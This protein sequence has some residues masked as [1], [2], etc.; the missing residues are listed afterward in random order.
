MSRRPGPSAPYPFRRPQAAPVRTG[1]R[2]AV[3]ANLLAADAAAAQ[4]RHFITEQLTAWQLHGRLTDRVKLL[5]SELITNA[6]RHAPP[7]LRIHLAVD[8][9]RL[10]V[11][12]YDSSATPP[13]LTRPDFHHR[14][15]R[16]V[17]LVDAMSSRWGHHLHPPGKAVWFEIDL[18][19]AE[20]H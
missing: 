16:G 11:E 20:D 10:R 9:D 18:A 3:L 13:A 5:T 2:T 12:V 17:W 19:T 15:G 1:I 8:A 6:V 7:P 4:G 14:G